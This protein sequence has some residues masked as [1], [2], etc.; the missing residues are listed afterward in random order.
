MDACPPG[1]AQ[2]SY[3]LATLVAEG[4]ALLSA[5]S[6][7]THTRCHTE[8]VMMGTRRERAERVMTHTERVEYP[9]GTRVTAADLCR[10]VSLASGRSENAAHWIGSCTLGERNAESCH[11]GG[12]DRGGGGGGAR[13]ARGKWWAVWVVRVDPAE[14]CV[15]GG[16][17]PSCFYR[18]SKD[19]ATSS[20]R[21]CCH[22]TDATLSVTVHGRK[23]AKSS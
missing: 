2:L 22:L 9:M 4:L 17:D 6:A 14:E 21:W 11:I 13:G 1:P 23:K 19:D 8:R 5:A 18:P 10:A 20:T 15:W 16:G 7:Q 3:A 12:G